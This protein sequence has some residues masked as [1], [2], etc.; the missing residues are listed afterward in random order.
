MLYHLWFKAGFSRYRKKE[1]N[2]RTVN[3]LSQARYKAKKE[4][5]SSSEWGRVA[6]G[7]GGMQGGRGGGGSEESVVQRSSP[8]LHTTLVREPV[9]R[10]GFLSMID[11]SF[12]T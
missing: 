10:P 9:H 5:E 1:K 6:R 8:S 11:S 7:T 12:I 2:P 4:Q 3:R